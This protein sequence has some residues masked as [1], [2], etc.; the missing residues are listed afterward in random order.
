MKIIFVCKP[1]KVKRKEDYYDGTAQKVNEKDDSK[2]EQI[3]CKVCHRSLFLY[4]R[5]MVLT[6][7]EGTFATGCFTV[8]SS[9]F[10]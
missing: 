10:S 3:D 4:G 2:T 7:F 5:C 1:V 9:C 8:V 6:I